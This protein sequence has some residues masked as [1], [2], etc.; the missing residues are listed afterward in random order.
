MK[1]VLKKILKVLL[2]LGVLLYFIFVIY[3]FL[4]S[5]KTGVIWL[6][7][8]LLTFALFGSFLE[9]SKNSESK[10]LTNGTKF[11]TAIL[12][13][14]AFSWGAN[15]LPKDL[16]EKKPIK[17]T[18]SN[19]KTETKQLPSVDFVKLNEFQKKWSDSLIKKVWENNYFKSALFSPKFD[20]IYFTLIAKAGTGKWQNGAEINE[21]IHKQ[22]YDSLLLKT[23]GN[24]FANTNT[25]IKII[26][27]PEQQKLNEAKAERQ[28]LID[29]QFAGFSGAN[30]YVE[31]VIKEN[32]NDPSSFEFVSNSY[33]DKGTYILVYIKFRGANAF[34]ATILQSVSAKVDLEGNV[35][36]IK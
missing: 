22:E 8:A 10:P 7:G 29:R 2:G 15:C 34:G 19:L 32:M 12:A 24:E 4:H 36:S 27:D 5:W 23:F 9:T 20:T 3:G 6:V 33:V 14:I 13:F 16:T 17:Q 25:Q 21:R 18:E 35:L 11:I 1:P 26:A 31:R 28:H 30:H